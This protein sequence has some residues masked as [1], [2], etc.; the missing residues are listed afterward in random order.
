PSPGPAP[1][2]RD[3]RFVTEVIELNYRE[4][5]IARLVAE[6][7]ATAEVKT[8]ARQLASDFGNAS[9]ELRAL[10]EKKHIVLPEAHGEA[11]D[12]K[13]WNERSSAEVDAAYVRRARATL[14][15][16]AAR[17]A[18]AVEKSADPELAAF[19]RK[20][21]AA[22]QEQQRRAAQPVPASR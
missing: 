8:L 14:D 21:L 2:H 6:R 1:E 15:D 13:S 11:G 16:L 9:R 3:T 19:A 4:T 5:I 17:Y 22:V 20:I 12:L 7:A 10:A 18:R